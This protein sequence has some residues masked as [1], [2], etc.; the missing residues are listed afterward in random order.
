MH[1]SLAA[2]HVCGVWQF[3]SGAR[4][5]SVGL[6]SVWTMLPSLLC[7]RQSQYIYTHSRSQNVLCN[8]TILMLFIFR[9]PEWSWPKDGAVWSVLF[10]K[11]VVKLVTQ[12]ASYCVMT[13]TSATIPTVLIH[14]FT[15]FPKEP[16]SASGGS[17]DAFLSFVLFYLLSVLHLSVWMCVLMVLFVILRCVCCIQCG[18]TSPGLNCEWMNNYSRC[19]PCASLSRCPLCHREYTHDDLILQCQQCDR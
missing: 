5:S 19:G 2:G 3:W 18:S 8:L 16:G 4:R 14:P 15:Q 17:P 12:L 9:L 6:F 13:V 7:Q 1:V 10:V 11:R